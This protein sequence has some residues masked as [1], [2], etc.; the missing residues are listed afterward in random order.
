[1]TK[2]QK[3]LMLAECQE[4][5]VVREDSS[6]GQPALEVNGNFSWG[7]INKQEDESDGDEKD[8]KVNEEKKKEEHTIESKLHLKD[9]KITVKEGQF[10]CVIGKAA[11]GKST[12]LQSIIGDTISLSDTDIKDLGGMK[13]KKTDRKSVV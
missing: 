8:A 5:L 4:N 1:M 2:I 13:A 11:S 6:W 3:C 12:L 10:V 7:L 9:V